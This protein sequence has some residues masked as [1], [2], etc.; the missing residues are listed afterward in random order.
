MTLIGTKQ[1]AKILGVTVSRLH[2]AVWLERVPPPAKGPS[3]AF[4]WTAEDLRRAYRV[5]HGVPMP[6]LPA[7]MARLVASTPSVIA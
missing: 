3:G 2:Q 1:A 4:V 7:D 6:A 5:L